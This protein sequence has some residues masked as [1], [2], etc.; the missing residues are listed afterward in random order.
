MQAK[1]YIG[2]HMPTKRVAASMMYESKRVSELSG[3]KGPQ[4]Q[5]THSAKLTASRAVCCLFELVKFKG[6]DAANT[7]AD[8]AY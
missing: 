4:S 1:G 8:T 5:N 3:L 7:V 2:I 6:D